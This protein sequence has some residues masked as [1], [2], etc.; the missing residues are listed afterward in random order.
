MGFNIV[1]ELDLTGLFI[2]YKFI[3]PF[4]YKSKKVIWVF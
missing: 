3:S 4:T 2:I 1:S